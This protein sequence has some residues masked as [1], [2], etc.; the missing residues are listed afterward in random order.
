MAGIS[1]WTMDGDD[2]SGSC[3]GV[4]YPLVKAGR[5]VLLKK[6]IRELTLSSD[7]SERDLSSS[8][9]N[10]NQTFIYVVNNVMFNIKV[11]P[12]LAI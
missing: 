6:Y 4:S 5:D 3:H 12:H 8:E 7:V 11:Y 2:F 9:Q 10:G 1:F